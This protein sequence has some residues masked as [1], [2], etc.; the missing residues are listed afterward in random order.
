MMNFLM[1]FTSFVSGS[2]LSSHVGKRLLPS[3]GASDGDTKSSF[4]AR[5]KVVGRIIVGLKTNIYIKRF[6]IFKHLSKEEPRHIHTTNYKHEL[7][8]H[9]RLHPQAR[10][11]ERT[12]QGTLPKV[13][14]HSRETEFED[15]R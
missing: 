3:P 1:G 8:F 5:S 15:S 7:Y 2:S 4:L 11:G 12:A 13:R 14:S 6:F 9:H 10:E